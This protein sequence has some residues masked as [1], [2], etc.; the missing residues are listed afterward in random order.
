MD[1]AYELARTPSRYRD[2]RE[3]AFCDAPSWGQSLGGLNGTRGAFNCLSSLGANRS[4]GES[5]EHVAG[6]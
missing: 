5:T 1:V 3:W 4:R 2:D 6:W